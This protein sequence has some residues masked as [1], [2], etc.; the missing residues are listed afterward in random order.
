MFY[1]DDVLPEETVVEL[2][3]PA[4]SHLAHWDSTS[5]VEDTGWIIHYDMDIASFFLAQ[6]GIHVEPSP[7]FLFFEDYCSWYGLSPTDVE[8]NA[9]LIEELETLKRRNLRQYIETFT[10]R[11]IAMVEELKQQGYRKALRA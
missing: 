11:R 9:H 3:C 10:R 5:M 8:E 7:E 2:F 6:K 4:C 1:R